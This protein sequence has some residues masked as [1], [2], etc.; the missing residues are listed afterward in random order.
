MCTVCGCGPGETRVETP[1]P[2]HAIHRGKGPAGTT[3]AGM[4]QGRLVAIEKDILSKN[5]AIAREN[6]ARFAAEDVLVLNLMSSPGAGKTTLLVETMKRL[7]PSTP[8]A[9]IEGDQE[10]TND[11]DRIRATGAP[12]IQI[13][14]G[15]GC[16]LDA[17]MVSAAL[18]RLPLPRGGVLFVENVGNLVC[19]A[20]F[21]LG[22]AHKV[23]IASVTEGED[24]PLKYPGM[25]AASDLMIVSKIDLAPHCDV[26]V[27]AYVRSARRVNP[28]IGALRV[29]TRTGAGVPDWLAWISAARAFRAAAPAA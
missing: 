26:D 9:V 23:V 13:N 14:T 1:E 29:S 5:D 27:E 3:V 20:G 4:T 22:E 12:A 15:K 8:V 24:K 25:F 18:D 6:R 16:H 28:R 17:E 21:D 11:A 2:A 19:P 7:M 10:T